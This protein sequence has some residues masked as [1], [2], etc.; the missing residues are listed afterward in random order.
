MCVLVA[1]CAA[2]CGRFAKPP[3]FTPP[4]EPAQ[5]TTTVG[6][7]SPQAMLERMASRYANAAI[8]SS[9]WLSH[10]E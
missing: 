7:P 9:T 10:D 1:V 2:S 4:G 8:H 6:R 3:A 5:P